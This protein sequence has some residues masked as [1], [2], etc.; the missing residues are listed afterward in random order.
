MVLLCLAMLPGAYPHPHETPKAP[1][2]E[3]LAQNVTTQVISPI[4]P[5]RSF[6]GWGPLDISCRKFTT[7]PQLGLGRALQT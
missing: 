4:L 7:Y 6:Q 3:L 1:Q 5:Q 2:Q